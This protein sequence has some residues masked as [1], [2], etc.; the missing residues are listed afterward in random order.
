MK[1]FRLLLQAALIT[2]AG[3]AAVAEDSGLPHWRPSKKVIAKLDFAFRNSPK[4]H[5]APPKF[6]DY[7]RYYA[8]VTIKG[9]RMIRAEFTDIPNS[10]RI[11]KN[12][13]EFYQDG[14]A[15]QVVS[16]DKFPSI[17]D[18]GCGVVNVLYD[19]TIDRMV[20][21]RCNGLA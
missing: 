11:V 2:L 10:T 13:I 15:V 21:L 4:W 20:W 9:R 14:S 8:G 16:V 3:S 7:Y 18:G 17:S 6:D 19:V 5:G 12:E 1:V